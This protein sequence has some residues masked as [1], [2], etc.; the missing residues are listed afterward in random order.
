MGAGRAIVAGWGSR[1]RF[2]RSCGART[3]ARAVRILGVEVAPIVS[4]CL[5]TVSG[6]LTLASPDRDQLDPDER[7]PAP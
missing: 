5:T 4:G 1:G 3:V 7:G 2:G 6:C